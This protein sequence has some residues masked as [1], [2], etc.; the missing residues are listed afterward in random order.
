MSRVSR[1]LN[2]TVDLWRAVTEDDGGG[3]QTT[4]WQQQAT[5]PARRSQPSARDRTAA[6]QASAELDQVW[7]F[8]P[9]ADVRRG[10][11]L[12]AGGQVWQ[13]LAVLAPSEPGTYLRADCSAR[14]PSTGG[15]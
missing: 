14:Q 4:T 12:R 10:D 6:A 9:A 8:G 7:Y 2:T 5:L 13:V 15:P 1:L 11:E 3:G